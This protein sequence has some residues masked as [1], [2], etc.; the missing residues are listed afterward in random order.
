MNKEIL[1][2]GKINGFNI[3]FTKANDCSSKYSKVV[4]NNPSSNA[5]TEIPV[6]RIFKQTMVCRI[7][8]HL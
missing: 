1:Y 6:I 8:D 4:Q 2:F 7:V 5:E 3:H